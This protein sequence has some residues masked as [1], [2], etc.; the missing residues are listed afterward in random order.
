MKW[1][2]EIEISKKNPENRTNK[3]QKTVAFTTCLEEVCALD[4][5]LGSGLGAFAEKGR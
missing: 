4:F 1:A 2:S 5:F 3:K